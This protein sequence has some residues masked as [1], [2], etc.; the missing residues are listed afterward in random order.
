VR[1]LL[2]RLL[3]LMM[4]LALPLQGL[5]S[6]SMIGCALESHPAAPAAETGGCHEVDAL[7]DGPSDPHVCGH[8]AACFL[9]SVPLIPAL[10]AVAPVAPAREA[11]VHTL[12]RY[13]GFIPEGPE[14]PPRTSQ[15]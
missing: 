2:R 15:A 4:M 12:A 9:V 14:R 13:G 6:A 10:D 5:A 7:P 8:C 1:T 3:L 11:I